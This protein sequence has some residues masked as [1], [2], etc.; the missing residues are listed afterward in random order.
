MFNCLTNLFEKFWTKG[1][2]A[3]F[4]RFQNYDIGRRDFLHRFVCILKEIIEPRHNGMKTG[5]IKKE[6]EPFSVRR[7][8]FWEAEHV[9]KVSTVFMRD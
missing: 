4:V 1:K 6:N 8:D 9:E 5:A 3:N 2:E 7:K